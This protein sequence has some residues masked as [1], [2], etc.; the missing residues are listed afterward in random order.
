MSTSDAP[1]EARANGRF[2]IENRSGQVGYLVTNDEN[3]ALILTEAE[4]RPS[5]SVTMSQTANSWSY[6]I[7]VAPEDAVADSVPVCVMGTLDD[8]TPVTLLDAGIELRDIG[9]SQTHTGA[10]L[11]VGAHVPSSE[12][13]LPCARIALPNGRAWR[14][15]H[16]SQGELPLQLSD[17]QG[18]LA[19]Y[20][21]DDEVWVELTLAPGLTER[22]WERRFW[23]PCVTL[24]NLWTVQ[25]LRPDQVQFR[26]SREDP[27]ASLLTWR[28][29]KASP[30]TSHDSLLNPALL[31]LAD[32]AKAL[33]LFEKWAPI[34]E[35]ASRHL[36]HEVTLE[37]AVLSYAASLEGLHRRCF[38]RSKPFPELSRS[39]SRTVAKAAAAA[40]VE[41]VK[42]ADPLPGSE[43]DA[44]DRFVARFQN[45]NEPTFADRLHELMIPLEDVAPGLL[46]QDRHRWVKSIV[47]AR[48]AEAHRLARS[49]VVAHEQHIDEYYQLAVSAEWGLRLSVLMQLG[50]EAEVL[51]QRLQDHQKF[52]FALANMDRC[53]HAW[54]G[55][56]LE[57][58]RFAASPDAAG[59]NGNLPVGSTGN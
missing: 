33:P 12:T 42:Q 58:L 52:H 8:G 4:L 34:P 14:G 32:I 59:A 29:S 44:T 3:S 22:E 46:G 13:L 57:E 30:M 24:L 45:F 2:W 38:D 7:S 53:T 49:A 27:W 15:L 35:V 43:Q 41:A 51:H 25:R 20:V 28:G 54:S 16:H 26:L 11:L 47:S 48:N 55:S 6:E 50:I 5:Q 56:R 37:L 23:Y 17:T 1:L 31:G 39:L 18:E 21:E 19:A 36:A 40:A 9:R 10:R